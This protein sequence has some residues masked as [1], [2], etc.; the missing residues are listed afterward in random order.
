[1]CDSYTRDFI[2]A[3]RLFPDINADYAIESIGGSEEL[4][5]KLVK[6]VARLLP[7]KIEQM[8]NGLCADDLHDFA[9]LVHGTKGSMH[10]IGCRK[11]AEYAESLELEAKDG[12]RQ[13]C[14][15]N[16]GRLKDDLLSFCEHVNAAA[17]ECSGEKPG[18]A[19][20]MPVENIKDYMDTIKQ[21]QAAT[22]DYDALAAA[23]LLTPLTKRRFGETADNLVSNLASALDSYKYRQAKECI[24][25]LIA[26]CDI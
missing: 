13:F 11:I 7:S 16:Y 2:E 20:E 10:Q 5:E 22:E 23:E 8:D 12:N 14:E 18:D 21:I 24:D 3:M 15:D 25:E 19:L 17:S 9:I 1:M 26:A 4:Y 6:K